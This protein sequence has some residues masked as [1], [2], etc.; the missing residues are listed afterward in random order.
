MHLICTTFSFR[1]GSGSKGLPRYICIWLKAQWHKT[2]TLSEIMAKE[3]ACERLCSSE[4]VGSF[5]QSLLSKRQSPCLFYWCLGWIDLWIVKWVVKESLLIKTLISH[6]HGD[7]W[8]W[9]HHSVHS[10]L[11][12]RQTSIDICHSVWLRSSYFAKIWEKFHL[13]KCKAGGDR[14][15]KRRAAV[16]VE[17]HIW[18]C[19][20][21]TRVG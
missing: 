13:S 18:F 14:L 9:Q 8:W 3:R 16:I 11:N 7:K 2:V 20:V 4:Q 10:E 15:Q 5:H 1:R 12:G 21:L 6:T 19:R 17:I